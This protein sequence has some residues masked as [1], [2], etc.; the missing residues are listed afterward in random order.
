MV[1]SSDSHGRFQFRGQR[2]I[3]I[4][5]TRRVCGLYVFNRV[6]AGPAFSPRWRFAPVPLHENHPIIEKIGH[7]LAYKN[8]I[9]TYL[10][11]R[12]VPEI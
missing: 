6:G 2:G 8:Y 9:A 3:S 12:A 5:I 4:L 7:Q 10:V 11:Y 1:A